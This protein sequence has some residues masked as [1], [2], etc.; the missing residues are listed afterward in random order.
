[1][2]PFVQKKPG[3]GDV[4]RGLLLLRRTLRRLR[5]DFADDEFVLDAIAQGY[6][7]GVSFAL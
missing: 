6:A 3:V 2:F 4:L 1:M 5:Q 7:V